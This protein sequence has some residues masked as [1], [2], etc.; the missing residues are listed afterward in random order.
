LSN[1][2]KKGNFMV[3]VDTPNKL[4]HLTLRSAAHPG[5]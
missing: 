2:Q 3:P 5:R 4:I 1:I